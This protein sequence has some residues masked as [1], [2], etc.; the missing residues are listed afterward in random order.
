MRTESVGAC[1]CANVHFTLTVTQNWFIPSTA[2]WKVTYES[3]ACMPSDRL[4]FSFADPL[5]RCTTQTGHTPPR[6]NPS[7]SC[8]RQSHLIVLGFRQSMNSIASHPPMFTHHRMLIQIRAQLQSGQLGRV[9]PGETEQNVRR[10]GNNKFAVLCAA[11]FACALTPVAFTRYNNVSMRTFNV[12]IE[13]SDY[14]RPPSHE[15]GTNA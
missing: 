5:C 3:M 12:L 4:W 6:G 8:L 7:P 13:T 2:A 11:S 14:K 1:A 15:L 9:L 10:P